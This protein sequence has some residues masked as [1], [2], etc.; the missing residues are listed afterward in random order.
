MFLV[1][2]VCFTWAQYSATFN[3][4]RL[5]SAEDVFTSAILDHPG[6]GDEFYALVD[7]PKDFIITDD[8]ISISGVLN[9]SVVEIADLG[10]YTRF[11]VSY[12]QTTGSSA[13]SITL[14]IGNIIAPTRDTDTVYEYRIIYAFLD[15]NNAF[16]NPEEPGDFEL[17]RAIG[18]VEFFGGPA[19]IIATEDLNVQCDE[20]LVL[21]LDIF[22][23]SYVKFNYMTLVMS[24]ELQSGDLALNGPYGPVIAYSFS[25]NGNTTYGIEFQSPPDASA[26]ELNFTLEI[27]NIFPPETVEALTNFQIDMEL[28]YF[29]IDNPS[30]VHATTQVTITIEPCENDDCDQCI[31]SFSPFEGEK[32]VLSAWVKESATSVITYEHAVISLATIANNVGDTTICYADGQII[33]GWQRIEYHFEIPSGTDFLSIKL[34]N[35]ADASSGL[36]AYFDDIRIHPYNSKMKSFVYSPETFRLMAELDENNYATFFEYDEDG[37]L[38][39]VKKETERGIK[40]IRESRTNIAKLPINN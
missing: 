14:R 1:M 6:N 7:I 16:P 32:Y 9:P 26:D 35:L 2:Q 18:T 37:V 23:D 20:E 4:L 34:K 33:D 22:I 17:A 3:D 10:D 5:R 36:R 40:T 31:Q 24:T 39:R 29:E 11:V 15:D 38:V 25:D 30:I 8:T 21:P 12:G 28:G 19:A 13:G 27:S